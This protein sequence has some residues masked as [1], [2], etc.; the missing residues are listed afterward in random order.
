MSFINALGDLYQW[1]NRRQANRL[2][3]M[4]FIINNAIQIH[5]MALVKYDE[6]DDELAKIQINKLTNKFDN[7][8]QYFVEEL[9]EAVATIAAAFFSNI[10]D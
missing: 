10:K 7:K 2:M 6:M 1:V 8:T 5:P 3:R 9:S 4:E